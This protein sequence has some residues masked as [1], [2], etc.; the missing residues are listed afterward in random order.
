LA[1]ERTKADRVGAVGCDDPHRLGN[2]VG[3][4]VACVV[5]GVCALGGHRKLLSRPRHVRWAISII[6]FLI[7]SVNNATYIDTV[8]KKIPTTGAVL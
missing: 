7:D 8:N 3:S 4:E 2:K 6:A 1:G 5:N